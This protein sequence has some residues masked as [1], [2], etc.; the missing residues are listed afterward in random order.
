MVL[1]DL[2]CFC[3]FQKTMNHNCHRTQLAKTVDIMAAQSI[4]IQAPSTHLSF[5]SLANTNCLCRR[6]AWITEW[7]PS[8]CCYIH[9]PHRCLNLLVHAIFD[10]HVLVGRY[11]RSHGGHRQGHAPL[12]RD[13]D[14]LRKHL[15][16]SLHWDVTRGNAFAWAMRYLS[17][18]NFW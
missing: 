10:D 11:L 4:K 9:P 3:I 7:C 12:V 17:R 5:T 8:N 18:V 2:F 15:H 1:N 13:D 14:F 6:L 16:R